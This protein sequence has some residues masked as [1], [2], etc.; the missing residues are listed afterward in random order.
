MAWH[1]CCDSTA[2]TAYLQ[3]GGLIDTGAHF[4]K[5]EHFIIQMMAQYCE[6]EFH[7]FFH[8]ENIK[9]QQL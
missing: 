1:R 2:A 8:K 7:S 4:I 3:N 6:K 5:T 9:S